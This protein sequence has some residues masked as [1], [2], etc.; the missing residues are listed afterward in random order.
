MSVVENMALGRAGA[1]CMNLARERDFLNYAASL[2][3]PPKP[4]RAFFALT[5]FNAEVV[6]VRDHISQPM[7]GEIRLQWW[8][9]VL[10]GAGSAEGIEGNPVAAELLHA[11]KTYDLP[12]EMLVR[13]VDAHVFDVYD[14][15]MPD[16]AALEAHCRDTSA[17]L[18]MLRAKILGAA[19]PEILRIAEHAGIAEGFVDV[20]LSLPKHAARRQL[21]L[22]ADLMTFEGATAEEI[23]TRHTNEPLK[24][25]LAH[26]R[27]EAYTQ[28]DAA[29][30]MLRNAPREARPAFLPLA[31][32]A[33]TLRQLEKADPFSPPLMSRLAV[34]WTM[35]RAAR[36]KPFAA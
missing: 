29:M 36:S 24:E 19:P 7:P 6:H 27:D 28:R 30:A 12:V 25:V 13:L 9:D 10:T 35:W 22:P 32:V 17:A 21:Y 2:F 34:L 15:P 31:Q 8:R 14:D 5:A 20:M 16:M 11:I 18:Y 1:F 4:R 23:F 33:K 26:L 3:V